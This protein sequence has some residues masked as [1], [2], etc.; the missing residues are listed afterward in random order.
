MSKRGERSMS[1][2]RGLVAKR[3]LENLDGPDAS[4]AGQRFHGCPTY[5]ERRMGQPPLQSD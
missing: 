5:I 4:N 1:H 3:S 2:G